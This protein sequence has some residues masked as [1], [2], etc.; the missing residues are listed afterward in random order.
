[1]YIVFL[2][3]TQNPLGQEHLINGSGTYLRC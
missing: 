3:N 2:S 1:M